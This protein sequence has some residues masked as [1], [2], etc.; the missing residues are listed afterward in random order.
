MRKLGILVLSCLFF[1][2]LARADQLQAI[3]QRGM[4]RIAV[5]QDFPPFGTVDRTFKPQ[6]YDIDTARYLAQQLHVKLQLVPVS[7]ASRIAYLQTNKVDLVISSLGKNAER[8]KVIDFSRAYAPMYL[9]VFGTATTKITE[10]GRLAGKTIGVTRGAVE[11][12][13]LSA[14]APSSAIIKRYEDN[15]TTLSAFLA[16]QVNYIA[17]GNIVIAAAKQQHP[18]H[19]PVYSFTLQD[20]PCFIGLNKGQLALKQQINRLVTKAMTDGTFNRLSIKW[21][22]SPLA[23]TIQKEG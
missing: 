9:G 8:A 10:I 14:M 3:L 15:N 23:L 2:T 12:M 5:P 11:D 6:G 17:T 7:S 20:S 13:V 21:M 16:G 22:K 19:A 18:M 1:S 4:I